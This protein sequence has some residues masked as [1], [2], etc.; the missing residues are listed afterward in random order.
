MADA[1]PSFPIFARCI[2]RSP[3]L[4]RGRRCRTL[5][6][7]L[8]DV[9]VLHGREDAC[10]R[11]D[12]ALA[13]ARA[14]RSAALL[15]RG[16]AGIGKSA[17]LEYARGQAPDMRLLRVQGAESEAELGYAGLHAL[18]HPV[19]E[20]VDELPGPQRCALSVA[21]GLAEGGSADRFLVGAGL[22]T[23][24]AEVA[25][26]GPVLCLVDDLQWLDAPSAAAL[27]FAAR[28]LQAE[29]VLLL[30]ACRSGEENEA[31][32][33]GIPVL[34]LGPLEADAAA[35]LATAHAAEALREPAR[36]EVVRLAQGNPLALVE[37]ARV[38][39]TAVDRP[40]P[41]VP[42]SATLERAFLGRAAALP[43]SC[44]RVLVVASADDT[45][46]L[47]VVLAAARSL[48]LEPDA[49][50]PA[51]RLGIVR[52]AGG[53][54]EWRHPLV[55]SALYR[56]APLAE[57]EAAHTA[58]AD[59]LTGEANAERRAWHRAAAT[60][61]PDARVA[62]EL[63]RAAERARARGA[64]VSAAAA[65]ERAA[66]LTPDEETRA[67]RLATAA[68]AAFAGGAVDRA[69][70]SLE[71]AEQ[72][73][74][75][76]LQM[77]MRRLRGTIE[78]R[79]GVVLDGY[80]ILAE[81]GRAAAVE[82]PE[83]ATEIFTEAASAASYGGDVAGLLAVGNQAAQLDLPE[84]AD[85]RFDADMLAGVSAVLSRDAA[86]GIPLLHSALARG[87]RFS[88][89]ERL[90]RAGAAAM[91]AGDEPAARALHVRAVR[92]ARDGGSL[93]ALS[94][95]LE[96]VAA[97]EFATA[98]YESALA[99][100]AE[101]LDLAREA[102]LE[103]SAAMHL[104]VVAKVRAVQGH[105]ERCREAADEA[106]RIA[107]RHGLGLPAANA[108][109]A[110]A[111]LELGTGRPEDALARL[112]ALSTAGPGAGHPLVSLL[113]VPD[114]VEAAVRSGT[115]ERAA[116]AVEHYGHWASATALPSA[117]AALA[118]CRGLL[119]CSAEAQEQLEAALALEAGGERPFEQARTA[120]LLGELLRR[121][122]RRIDARPYLRDALE[123]FVRL[124]TT[125]WAER[126]AGELRASGETARRREVTTRE[127]L[128]PQERQ[129]ARLV[130]EGATNKQVAAALFLS[131]KTVE[132]H[133]GKV[134][135]KLG[136]A[137]RA[138]LARLRPAG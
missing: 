88:D 46:D 91:W 96:Y 57:R 102:G 13:E 5:P 82:D 43:E 6:A 98:H 21:L 20:E 41:E 116:A 85:A 33:D 35:A 125:P 89:P 61:A 55:R 104:A 60:V 111:L 10:A 11:I 118:R 37:L 48:G 80:A 128:T 54:V 77:R 51:E 114:L 2:H 64:H 95:A 101:G 133:L 122:R 124:G 53:A 76:A 134:F 123:T 100:A 26:E 19:A 138:E 65:L 1:R 42:L 8:Y 84:G 81:A 121:E 99:D 67:R 103:R 75:P 73:G 58:L 22:V 105:A 110:L 47:G 137:S 4:A 93:A 25:E 3:A 74:L 113:A 70:V 23:L 66:D 120:L 30:C 63:E 108:T 119:A 31:R 17:L 34:E 62:D 14:G 130:S 72:L 32:G 52:T 107:S 50:A 90:V 79:R 106:L 87:E 39:H 127:D 15:V 129:I 7:P 45:R 36:E 29:G 68:D 115:P 69:R 126:A 28:R 132:Y 27:E 97:T 40:A 135:L 92:A 131:P 86:R 9:A 18:L 44:L 16:E 117:L 59:A 78:A 109:T 94:F 83:A 112:S 56:R 136:I 71:R 38:A 24:L 12:A 49:L